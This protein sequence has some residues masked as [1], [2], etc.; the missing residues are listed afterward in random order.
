MWPGKREE[1]QK[2]QM[3]HLDVTSLGEKE[4]TSARNY[5]ISP[6]GGDTI[7]S[8]VFWWT[9]YEVGR[10]NKPKRRE[11]RECRLGGKGPCCGA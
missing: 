9:T 2:S 4:G 8:G 3:N 6:Y 5:P 7:D 1:N 11:R 10:K